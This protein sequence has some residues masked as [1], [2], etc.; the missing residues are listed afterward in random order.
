MIVQNMFVV[1]APTDTEYHEERDKHP[2]NDPTSEEAATDNV[3][4]AYPC[5]QPMKA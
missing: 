2:T 1:L 5:V 3:P 4:A